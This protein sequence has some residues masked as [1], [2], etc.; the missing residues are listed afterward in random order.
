MS[1][2][3]RRSPSWSGTII[4]SKTWAATRES[5]PA[6]FPALTTACEWSLARSSQYGSDHGP[7]QTDCSGCGSARYRATWVAVGPVPAPGRPQSPMATSRA[8]RDGVG[9]RLHRTV[10]LLPA[11]FV[12]RARELGRG[13]QRAASVGYAAR[14]HLAARVGHWRRDVLHP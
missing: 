13:E 5:A 9:R 1:T 3:T 14:S 2:A 8:G 6:R 7:K 12:H 11:D 10:R 4:S